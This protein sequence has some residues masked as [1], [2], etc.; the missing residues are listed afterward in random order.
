[1][2]AGSSSPTVAIDYIGPPT[3]LAVHFEPIIVPLSLLYAFGA[4]PRILLVFQTLAL[5]VGAL[6]VFLLTRHFIRS[7]R[8]LAPLMAF[9]YCFHP[10]CWAST[11]LI[12]TR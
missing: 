3:R 7:G 9:A 12:F 6:P 2:G 1:M 4:D 8:W 5:V 10:L 11:F